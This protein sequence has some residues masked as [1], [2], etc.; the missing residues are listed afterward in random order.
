MELQRISKAGSV[1]LVSDVTEFP[2]I[3]GGRV[4]TLH[5][6]IHGGILARSTREHQEDLERHGIKPIQLVAVNLY[7]FK[8]TIERPGVTLEERRKHRYRRADYGSG[9]SQEFRASHCRDES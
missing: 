2:E 6:M 9:S 1:T 4:K 8:K 5:P 7:P 3:L